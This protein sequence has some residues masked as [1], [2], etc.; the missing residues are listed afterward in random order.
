MDRTE[1]GSAGTPCE[2]P[3]HS[4]HSEEREGWRGT[5]GGLREPTTKGVAPCPCGGDGSNGD[6]T[7]WGTLAERASQTTSR[8]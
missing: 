5:L 8:L 2:T 3:R 6:D 4:V 7:R 1:R